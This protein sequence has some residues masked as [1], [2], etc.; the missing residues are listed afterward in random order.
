MKAATR[1]AL[2][3]LLGGLVVLYVLGFG[4]AYVVWWRTDEDPPTLL[5]LLYAPVWSVLD[6]ASSTGTRRSR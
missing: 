3:W 4:V 6:R 2:W 5:S 1:R